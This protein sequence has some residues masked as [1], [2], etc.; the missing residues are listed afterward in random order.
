MAEE[1]QQLEETREQVRRASEALEQEQ[2]TQA[3]ASGTRA[4][5]RVRGAAER[6]PPPGLRPLQ[7]RDAADARG[8]PGAR[9]AAAGPVAAAEPGERS[10]TEKSKSLRD[11]RRARAD[12][13]GAVAAAAA[14]GQLAGADAGDDHRRP[15]RP[16][17]CSPSGC[18]TPP[19]TSRSRS[20][21]GRWNRPSGRCGRAW[22]NDARQQQEPAGA[23]HPPAARGNRAG[24]RGRARRRDRSPPPRPRRSCKTCRAS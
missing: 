14:A 18:T 2:V 19:A 21:S 4:E 1:R 20:P 22:L 17:R 15:R 9:R 13:R 7:R 16:S 6:V 3:A 5:Q 10:P 12:R 23:E 8:R 11:T 24:G